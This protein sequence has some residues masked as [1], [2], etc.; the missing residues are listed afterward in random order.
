MLASFLTRLQLHMHMLRGSDKTYEVS[1]RPD[2]TELENSELYDE[3]QLVS[4][5]ADCY[6]VYQPFFKHYLSYHHASALVVA[7]ED[8]HPGYLN[9][10]RL[11]GSLANHAVLQ[12][13]D[14]S[15][16]RCITLGSRMAKYREQR[17]VEMVPL[18]QADLLS[19]WQ[20]QQHH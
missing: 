14:A 13:T 17:Q 2:E 9:L 20:V 16:R 8:R 19:L 15:G 7:C 3:W 11:V 5:G 10:W 1:C 12:L 6:Q 4:K 18:D